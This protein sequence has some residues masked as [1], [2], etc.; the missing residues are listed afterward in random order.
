MKRIIQ[1]AL[2]ALV[3]A[4]P[5]DATGF[6][7]AAYA[8]GDRG[9]PRARVTPER[10]YPWHHDD[11]WQNPRR[12]SRLGDLNGT[13][14]M[15]GNEDQPCRIIQ[16]RRSSRVLFINEQG[17]RARGT[18]QGDRV[19]IPDWTDGNGSTGLWGTIRGQRIVWPNGSYWSR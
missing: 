11:G 3:F 13:W 1:L 15:S 6:A 19:F 10:I 18:V 16:S 5:V 12:M 9:D 4:G 2:L 17:S 7:R 8:M 14:Y